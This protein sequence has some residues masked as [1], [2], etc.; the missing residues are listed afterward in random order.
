MR[1]G[2]ISRGTGTEGGRIIGGEG[3]RCGWRGRS[4][5]RGNDMVEGENEGKGGMKRRVGG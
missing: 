1:G 4:R 5:R 3:E 2:R